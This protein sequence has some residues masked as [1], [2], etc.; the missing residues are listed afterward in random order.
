MRK[1]EQSIQMIQYNRNK[2]KKENNKNIN[3]RDRI[4]YVCNSSEM[5][6]EFHFIL[7]CPT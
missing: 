5:E 2:I 6:D 1:R 3:K 7:K 4:S